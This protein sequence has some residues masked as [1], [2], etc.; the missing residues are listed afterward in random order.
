MHIN[1]KGDKIADILEDGGFH[2]V[3]ESDAEK[4]LKS[5]P[6]SGRSSVNS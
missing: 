1:W 4:L 3:G 2:Q 6:R 5:H